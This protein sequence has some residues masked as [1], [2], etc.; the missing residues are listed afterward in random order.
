[1]K[2]VAHY[3]MHKP[4]GSFYDIYTLVKWLG[5]VSTADIE[6]KFAIDVTIIET[7]ED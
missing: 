4:E 3:E 2:K 6:H 7:K 1:M 5:N